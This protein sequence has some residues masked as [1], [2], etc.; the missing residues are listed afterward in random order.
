MDG[1]KVYSGFN[2]AIQEDQRL[3]R[4]PCGLQMERKR[5]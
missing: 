2:T 4:R 1:G 3:G 5:F